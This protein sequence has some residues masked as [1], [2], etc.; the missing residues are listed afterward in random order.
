ME[1]PALWAL[2]CALLCLDAR[3]QEV[4]P[5]SATSQQ[6]ADASKVLSSTGTVRYGGSV[7][8]A[9]T[10]VSSVAGCPTP[11]GRALVT[12]NFANLP[13]NFSA[14]EV[15][16]QFLPRQVVESATAKQALARN[17]TYALASGPAALVQFVNKVLQAQS[18]VA[19]VEPVVSLESSMRFESSEFAVSCLM[20]N[21]PQ[22][23]VP[24]VLGVVRGGADFPGSI[25]LAGNLATQS[26]MVRMAVHQASPL[27][28]PAE[29]G[30]RVVIQGAG[31]QDASNSSDLSPMSCVFSN[32]T[33]ST[34]VRASVQSSSH[35]TCISPPWLTYSEDLIQLNISAGG[36]QTAYSFGYYLHPLIRA[37]APTTGPR[38]GS[39]EATL[40]LQDSLQLLNS[41]SGVNISPLVRISGAAADGSDLLLPAALVLNGSALQVQTPNGSQPL[42]AGKHALSVSLNRQQ[43]SSPLPRQ[44]A[45]LAIQGPTV[46]MS[47]PYVQ[48]DGQSTVV[49]F[50]VE[51]QGSNALPVTVDLGLSQRS[52][53][54]TG[55]VRTGQAQVQLSMQ[56]VLWPAGDSGPRNVSLVVTDSGPDGLSLGA[57]IVTLSNATNAD[58]DLQRATTLVS[59]VPAPD[60]RVSFEAAPNQVAYRNDSV[61]LPINITNARIRIPAVIGYQL[62]SLTADPL[63]YIPPVNRSGLLAWDMDPG[64][65]LNLTVPVDWDQVPFQAEYRIGLEFAGTWNTA[66][67]AQQANLTAVHLFGVRPGQCPPGTVRKAAA[68][69]DAG[70]APRNATALGPAPP[71]AED[72]RLGAIIVRGHNG[73]MFD[74]SSQFQPDIAEYGMMVPETFNNATLCLRP[75]QDAS[76]V[77]VYGPDGS[78]MPM[79]GA[80][81]RRRLL[82]AAASAKAK[83]EATAAAAAKAIRSPAAAAVNASLVCQKHA[84]VLPLAAGQNAFT[85]KVTAPAW[86]GQAPAAGPSS[87]LK[88]S[89][90]PVNLASVSPPSPAAALA[91]SPAQIDNSTEHDLYMLSV[92]RLADASHAELA[93]LNVTEGDA[94]FAVCGDG[95]ASHPY[96]PPTHPHTS[97]RDGG[98]LVPCAPNM[99]IHLNVS[100]ETDWVAL[101]PGLRFPQVQ[102]IRVE[103]WDQVLS[104]GGDVSADQ[105]ADTT[106]ALQTRQNQDFLPA[107]IILGLTPGTPVKVPIV[108]VAEDG[109]TSLRYYVYILRAEDPSGN[110][111]LGAALSAA[112]SVLSAAEGNS[113]LSIVHATST[114]GAQDM[115]IDLTADEPLPLGWP[116]PPSHSPECSVC[117]AGWAA[118]TV[119]AARCQLCSPGSYAAAPQSPACALCLAGSYAANWGST[120]CPHCIIGTYSPYQGSRLCTMCPDNMTNHEDG[121]SNCAIP[122]QPGTNLTI[123]YA[124]I[125]SFGVFFN[126]TTLDEIATRVG[127]NATSEAVL[128]HLIRA[129]TANAFNISQGD[130]EVTGISQVARRLLYV[131]VTATLGVDVPPGA[132][133]DDIKTALEVAN[134]SADDP[135]AMLSKNPDKFFGRTT[136]ALDVTASSDG[137]GATRLQS[138]PTLL[139]GGSQDLAW[140]A[141]LLIVLGALIVC[142][143]FLRI[144]RRRSK[145]FYA[146]VIE[147]LSPGRASWRRSAGADG[148]GANDVGPANPSSGG[149]ISRFKALKP[150]EAAAQPIIADAQYSDGTTRAR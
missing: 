56:S 40:M 90:Q 67:V 84:W 57:L 115:L 135:I 32:G 147:R 27:A 111:T 89:P 42:T 43:F 87:A 122:V 50:G 144:W 20:P 119:D 24:V 41:S 88:L 128:E 31:F 1:R 54:S 113:T 134:L 130:V 116:V 28:G 60:L 101:H 45:F 150:G 79:L 18:V 9:G 72:A 108:V 83:D 29:G 145:R 141:I 91:K 112:G 3:S 74:L 15:R 5:A 110:S 78:T 80:A 136:K 2:C 62:V 123:R 23:M 49:T 82:G 114:N 38:Y 85:I 39:F 124:V 109:V 17:G 125:I 33:A 96:T 66:G 126:G 44:E 142:G 36:C 46:S 12:V 100:Y 149:L 69:A 143:G 131:N 13:A 21:F 35:A 137:S 63:D 104:Q 146:A 140:W 81:N 86:A 103:V 68:A 22:P 71:A 65:V 16:C 107:A 118:T 64:S 120:H 93:L 92:V 73:T 53:I 75:I 133:E 127:V 77:E 94:V 47:E 98:V 19:T 8:L 59:A 30:T 14:L 26:S 102:G 76:L 148:E 117:P 95:S 58:L 34:S 48:Y 138:R 105:M 6:V 132:S 106:A 51:L 61:V 37:V 55:T 129:D 10:V 4:A 97:S 11:E 52:L 121:S 25:L 70:A 139:G 7:T 99:P